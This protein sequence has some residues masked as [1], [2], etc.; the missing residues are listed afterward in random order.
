MTYQLISLKKF[1][2]RKP[3]INMKT[4]KLIFNSFKKHNKNIM[5]KLNKRKIL[6]IKIYSRKT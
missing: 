6:R 1:Q 3:W 5:N 4:K 2:M